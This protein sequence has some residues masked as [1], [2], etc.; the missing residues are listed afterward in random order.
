MEDRDLQR[1][2]G[3]GS[4]RTPSKRP[5]AKLAAAPKDTARMQKHFVTFYSPGTFVSETTERAIAAWDVK[6][7]MKM[8]NEIIE[9][10]GATPYSFRFTTRSRG[11]NDL[12][13]KQSAQSPFYFL[14]GKVESVADVERRA[15]PK[16]SI[17]LSN[18]K[19]NGWN[20]IIT[21][22]N[23]WR[24]TQPLEDDDV[25]LDYKPPKRAVTRKAAR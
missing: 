2:N 20:R 16:E 22:D 23:S 8:A 4:R 19:G 15:D 11:P 6:A 18:M 17:L 10:Y 13:S 12:D 5:S 25:V 9:R 7:A 1:E 21:N 24:W 14:G 3:T